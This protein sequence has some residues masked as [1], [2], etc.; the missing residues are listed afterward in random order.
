ML[1]CRGFRARVFCRCSLSSV[2]FLLECRGNL[3]GLLPVGSCISVPWRWPNA[4]CPLPKDRHRGSIPR[5]PGECSLP[6]VISQVFRAG[7]PLLGVTFL[8]SMQSCTYSTFPMCLQS[9]LTPAGG[10]LPGVSC[11][12][13]PFGVPFC[14]A[15]PELPYR[16]LPARCLAEV[17]WRVTA[18]SPLVMAPAGVT[19]PVVL[20]RVPCGVYHAKV[21]CGGPSSMFH[22]GWFL[23][24]VFHRGLNTGYP[25]M[26]VQFWRQSSEFPAE[27]PLPGVPAPGSTA[28]VP[29]LAFP[30]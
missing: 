27:G 30:F 28:C 6:G 23:P 17:P 25:L 19:L 2:F 26:G 10:P 15:L 11:P 29:L 21:P 3:V 14:G 12:V 7:F 5:G 13:F 4:G 1:A 8:F 24:G 20:C 22:A 16:G 18:G 9:L